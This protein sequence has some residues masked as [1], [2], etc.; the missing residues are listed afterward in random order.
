M[1]SVN[2]VFLMGNLTS[3]VTTKYTSGG[4]GVG[5]FGIAVN[6]KYKKDGQFVEKVGFFQVTVWGR[7]A[8]TCSEY[9]KKGSLVFLEGELNFESWE[10]PEGQKRTKVSVTAFNVQCL[11]QKT[12]EGKDSIPF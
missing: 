2:K 12:Q 9:L 8:E 1:P 4:S 3:D 10:T 5:D 7:Q 6:K 11:D